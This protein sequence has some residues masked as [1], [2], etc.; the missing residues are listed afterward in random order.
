MVNEVDNRNYRNCQVK[1]KPVRFEKLSQVC[2]VIFLLVVELYFPEEA[3]LRMKTFYSSIC[4][5]FNHSLILLNVSFLLTRLKC[6]VLSK[7]AVF[8]DLSAG[9]NAS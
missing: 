1:P 8:T 6:V 3:P 2:S 7:I 4:S 9:S 5:S